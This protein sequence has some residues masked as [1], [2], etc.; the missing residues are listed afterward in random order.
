MKNLL[1]ALFWVLNA[2]TVYGE[3]QSS[4]TILGANFVVAVTQK[5]G[6]ET[7]RKSR[8]GGEVVTYTKS[9]P[10]STLRLGK[11][12]C[13]K[14][15]NTWYIQVNAILEKEGELNSIFFRTGKRLVGS[16]EYS[17]T[18]NLDR[19]EKKVLIS[20]KLSDDDMSYILSRLLSTKKEFK[21]GQ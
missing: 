14:S 3:E 7:L 6:V 11:S 16:V 10:D 17:I 9:I 2:V 15:E 13:F 12:I 21:K 1:Y 20:V 5:E 18:A 19:G 4:A 8:N